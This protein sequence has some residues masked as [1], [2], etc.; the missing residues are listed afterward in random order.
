MADLC[1]F[2]LKTNTS[3]RSNTAVCNVMLCKQVQTVD[4][5]NQGTKTHTG[6][7]R[8]YRNTDNEQQRYIYICHGGILSK[9]EIIVKLYPHKSKG[10][11]VIAVKQWNS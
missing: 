3:T 7:I 11:N 4:W 2:P 9:V 5:G 1:Y 10:T 8:T 6:S